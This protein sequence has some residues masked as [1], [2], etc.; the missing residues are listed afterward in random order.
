MYFDLNID[1]DLYHNYLMRNDQQLG[2]LLTTSYSDQYHGLAINFDLQ[3]Q[4]L[5]DKHI[6]TT[7]NPPT[8]DQLHVY[9]RITMSF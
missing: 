6:L 1:Q 3:H 9:S 2:S 7:F 4:P 5:L 8:H